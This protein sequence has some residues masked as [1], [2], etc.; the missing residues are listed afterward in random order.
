MRADSVKGALNTELGAVQNG[1]Q[2]NRPGLSAED[3]KPCEEAALV[4]SQ[5]NGGLFE[6]K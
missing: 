5:L 2:F 6:I 4:P 1:C 3:N